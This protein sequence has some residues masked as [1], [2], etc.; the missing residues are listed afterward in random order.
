S[1]NGQTGSEAPKYTSFPGQG[2]VVGGSAATSAALASPSSGYGMY[3]PPPAMGQ[4]GTPVPSAGPGRT[5]GGGSPDEQRRSPAARAAAEA[6][7]RRNEE[8]RKQA[9]RSER[10]MALRGRGRLDRNSVEAS[11]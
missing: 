7:E 1:T 9:L 5:L 11:K 3:A 8:R 6:A 2:N 4:A 10:N